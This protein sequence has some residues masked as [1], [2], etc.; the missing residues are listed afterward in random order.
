MKY[1]KVIVSAFI[2]VDDNMIEE[3]SFDGR[4]YNLANDKVLLKSIFSPIL[5]FE[6]Q[7]YIEGKREIV[8]YSD[9]SHEDDM[10]RE[11]I[12]LFDYDEAIFIPVDGEGNEL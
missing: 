5:A 11:G 8:D 2:E 3:K 1:Y 4:I 9:I 10:G 12:V 7:S 6:K